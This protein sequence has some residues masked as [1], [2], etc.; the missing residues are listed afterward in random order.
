[1]FDSK[2]IEDYLK[3]NNMSEQTDNFI[4]DNG[5]LYDP[6]I[7]K[8]VTNQEEID[9]INNILDNINDKDPKNIFQ[10]LEDLILTDEQKQAFHEEKEY[11]IK[12]EEHQDINIIYFVNDQ[13]EIINI[14]KG[15]TYKKKNSEE[16]YSYNFTVNQYNKCFIFD[17][18]NDYEIYQDKKLIFVLE[19]KRSF[20][21][22][23]EITGE[24]SKLILN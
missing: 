13:E 22:T 10:E 8:P 9:K 23:N 11:M 14:P 17:Q 4:N 20:E 5:I 19:Q 12:I 3:K 2:N 18:G 6:T 16:V 15:I 24:K 1:M 21:I 7:I